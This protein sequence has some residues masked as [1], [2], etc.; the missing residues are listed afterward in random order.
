MDVTCP[1]C[2]AFNRAGAKF[3][4]ACGKPLPAA[5]P[6]PPRPTAL[7]PAPLTPVQPPPSPL[8]ILPPQPRPSLSAPVGRSPRPGL[9]RAA[10]V[11]EGKVTAVDPE[12]QEKAPFDPARTLVMLAFVVV[13][14]GLLLGFAAAGMVVGIVLLLLGVGIGLLG[15]LAGLILMPLKLILAPIINFI[16]G[17]PTVTVLNFQVLDHA[18]AMPVDVLLYRKPGSGN[19]RVG[20]G[21]QVYGRVQRGSNVIRARRIRVVESGGRPT[22]YRVEGLRPWPIWIGLLIIGLAT[23]AA[24]QLAGII[25]IR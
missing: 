24:L 9:F 15:C 5:L 17:D 21:V 8:A 19:V 20:D 14:V 6:S 1:Q 22:D 11:V 10:P 16:R 2:G 7:P 4:A 12:R 13:V 25:N 18:T 3:C 23:L